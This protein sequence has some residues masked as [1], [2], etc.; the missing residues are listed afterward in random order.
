MTKNNE[1]RMMARYLKGLE[2]WTVAYCGCWFN[3]K[4]SAK[5][6][7][8]DQTE[9]SSVEAP[10]V[11]SAPV[12]AAAPLAPVIESGVPPEVVAAIAAA[13]NET[14]DGQYTLQSVAVAA[15]GAP[16]DRRGPWGLAGVIAHTEPF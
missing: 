2:S 12:P 15:T 3:N 11:V 14:S 10:R 9:T 8:K 5:K 13:V 7:Q 6:K 16:Q 4:S 1:L